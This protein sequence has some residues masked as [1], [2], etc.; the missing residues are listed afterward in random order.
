LLEYKAGLESMVV[1]NG[2]RLAMSLASRNLSPTCA[3]SE[4]WHGIHQLHFIKNITNDLSESKLKSLSDDL[5]SIGKNLFSSANFKIALIGE[6]N[7]LPA[8]S[9]LAVSMQDN[10]TNGKSNGFAA[11]EIE[12]DAEIIREGW[13]TSSAV[14]FVAQTFKT[15]RMEHEDAPAISVISKILRSMYLHREIREKGGAYGGFA[16]YNSEDGTFNFCSYRDPHIVSTLRV[17]EDAAN[18]INSGNYT[19]EDVKEAILQVCSGID[20][21]DTPGIAA[22][23]AFYRKIVSL[24]DEDRIRFKKRLLTLTRSKVGEAAEKYFNQSSMQQSVAVISGEEKLKEA[25]DKLA[26][27]PLNLYKI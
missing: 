18:F 25:N 15:V 23:K 21:P 9:S 12:F 8:A 4:T 11:P 16:L 7:T 17:Y 24:S 26:A 13:S 27:H 10:L 22:K 6:E 14:S 20:K 1:P 19:D 5:L 2:H 3:L